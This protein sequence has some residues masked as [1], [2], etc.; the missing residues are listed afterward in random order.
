MLQAGPLSMRFENGAIRG[1]KWGKTE[2]VRMVYGA[3]R[4]PNWI[5]LPPQI[6]NQDQQVNPDSFLV[7]FDAH[8]QREEIDFLAHYR[9]RGSANGQIDFE[10]SG[11]AQRSFQTNR[12]GLCVHLPLDE[13]VG[14][15]VTITSN[16]HKESS[17][18]PREVSPYQPFL[19]IEAMQWQ[20]SLLCSATL[21][22]EGE[23]FEAEDQ[24]NW[25]DASFKIYC[26]PLDWP[27][28]YELKA[29]ETVSQRI[30]LQFESASAAVNAAEGSPIS[31]SLTGRT[32]PLPLLG[33]GATTNWTP[34]LY[35]SA[36]AEAIQALLLSF[37]RAEVRLFESDWKQQW[38]NARDE[39][40]LLNCP[41]E[42]VLWFGAAPEQQLKQFCNLVFQETPPVESILLLQK[43][44]KV[45]P[46]SLFTQL[47]PRLRQQWPGVRIGG[48]TDAFFTELNRNRP[49]A[50]F[51][52]AAFTISPQVH[53]EDDASIIENLAAQT[54]VVQSA[55]SFWKAPLHVG[56]VTL[57]RR[58]NPDATTAMPT[59]SG[60][61]P[62]NVDTRQPTLLAAGWT[63]GSLKYLAQSEPERV[64]FYEV[65]GM[66]GLFGVGNAPA[67]F[68]DCEGQ[69]FP[70]YFVFQELVGAQ[71]IEEIISTAPLEV[72]SLALQ[73]VDGSQKLM[74]VNLTDE[75]KPV[76]V[77]IAPSHYRLLDAE[78]YPRFATNPSLFLNDHLPL[79]NDELCLPPYALAILEVEKSES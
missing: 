29:G 39:A 51:D 70:L 26:R 12:V 27:F 36:Q 74:L 49:C 50:P 40:D 43:G 20:P 57:R 14:K 4:D 37:L 64:T 2:V 69:F 21:K 77:P 24:R 31:I 63:L 34:S 11:V 60:E 79:T 67:P 13:C 73:M 8:Y 53:A 75:P 47:E 16:G 41:L 71:T 9:I 19:K 72:E 18:F 10:F 33:L 42:L 35:S 45:T 32:H 68:P 3:I 62:W 5:T 6:E 52:F 23:L 15:P 22:F 55:L 56:P 30:I 46:A 48:G 44:I 61:L 58:N 65:A 38:Q 54:H 28:P 78:S 17:Q 1:V 76:K 7:Q 59:I 25:T 66:R